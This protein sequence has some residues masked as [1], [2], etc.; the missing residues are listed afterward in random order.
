MRWRPAGTP[1]AFIVCCL[2]I[3]VWGI[4]G[5]VF[6]FSD[7]WQ[8]IINTGTTII[9]FLMVFLI[10]NT[11]N[12]DAATLHAKLDELVRVSEGRNAYIGI[13]HLS[14][15]D[16][17]EFRA[18]CENE[19]E[20]RYQVEQLCPQRYRRWRNNQGWVG[21]PHY[22]SFP[23]RCYRNSSRR[24]SLSPLKLGLHRRLTIPWYW[25]T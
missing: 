22:V 4:S 20:G 5:P 14:E 24:R 7:T 6:G 17:D 11:Q 23:D 3:L 18:D 9:T 16:V 21:L 13:E 10:Q 2:T 1:A 19:A 12:R 8:L 15:R 25:T